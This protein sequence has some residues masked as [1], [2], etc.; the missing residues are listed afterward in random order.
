M[1]NTHLETFD[2]KKRAGSKRILSTALLL[3]I[4][5]ACCKVTFISGYDPIIESTVS[6][7]Q[8]NFNL[9]FIKLAR[10]F[11]DNDSTNQKVKNFQD[12]YDNMNASLFVLKSRTKYL[13]KKGALVKKQITNLDSTLHAFESLHK[14]PG[15]KDSYVDDRHDIRDAVNASFESIIRLQEAVK[16]KK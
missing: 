8:K 1:K 11:Q 7:L 5:L 2:F 9:H 12:Y 14:S 6:E 3:A 10:T 16:P 4:L 15:F 13:D